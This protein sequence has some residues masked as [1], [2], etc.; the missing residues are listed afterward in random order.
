MDWKL[1]PSFGAARTVVFETEMPKKERAGSLEIVVIVS[2]VVG[3]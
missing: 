2:D 3:N 1:V